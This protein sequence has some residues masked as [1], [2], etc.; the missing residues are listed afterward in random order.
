[1]A[2]ESPGPTLIE[3]KRKIPMI[4]HAGGTLIMNG[5]A[6][7]VMRVRAYSTFELRELGRTFK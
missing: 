6:Q 2:K 4:Q 1:M 7:K 5:P 3:R